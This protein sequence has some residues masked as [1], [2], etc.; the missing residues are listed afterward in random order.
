MIEQYP[1]S[2]LT[3]QKRRQVLL[4]E[5][6][7]C[8]EA[9]VATLARKLGV[10]GMTVRRDLDQLAKDGRVI[11]T[12]GGAVP[13]QRVSFEFRFLERVRLH[14]EA[15]EAIA[16]TAAKLVADGEA[17]ILDSGTTTLAVAQQLITRSR[18][19][20][21]TTSLPI[22]AA[23]FGCSSVEV[24]LLGGF[25]RRDAPD[26]AGAVTERN[27]ETL[28]ADVAMVGADGIDHLGRV[29]NSSAEV[30]RMLGKMSAAAR[31]IYVV[32]DSSKIGKTAL[33]QFGD[34]R[35]MAGLITD[36]AL[37]PEMQ[38]QLRRAGVKVLIGT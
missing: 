38:K 11:R 37:P 16:R 7:G 13:T 6:N 31:R 22:A 20:V 35:N 23:L 3:G 32:A 10:S 17:I 19:T 24:L 21:I 15:K 8:E 34:L 33:M 14:R 2:T 36:A 28:R 5:I 26:L 30:A 29:Y 4:A 1:T 12:H 9:D 18:L 25:L 27:L